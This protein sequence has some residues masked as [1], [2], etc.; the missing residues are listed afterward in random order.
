MWEFLGA[1][2]LMWPIHA[3]FGLI[4]VLPVWF[5]TRRKLPWEKR[6]VALFLCPWLVLNLLV[7]FGGKDVSLTSLLFQNAS[8]GLALGFGVFSS[9]FWAGSVAMWRTACR[10]C[11][12][13]QLQ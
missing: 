4:V 1:V 3:I 6:D 5:F 2:A 7:L 12:R 9:S 10:S 8:L 11:S 13:A